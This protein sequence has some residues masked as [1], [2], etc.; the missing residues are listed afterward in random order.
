MDSRLGRRGV[1][2]SARR[3]VFPDH[4]SFM[5]GEIALYSLVILVITGVYLS[6]YFHPSSELVVYQGSYLP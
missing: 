6:F 1:A 4:W 5:L 2:R 3:L